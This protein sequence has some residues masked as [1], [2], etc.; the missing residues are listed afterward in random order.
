VY[1][2][3]DI[4]LHKLLACTDNALVWTCCEETQCAKNLQNTQKQTSF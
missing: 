1:K 2:S 4:P 3:V